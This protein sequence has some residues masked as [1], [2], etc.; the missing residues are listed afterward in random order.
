[1]SV[2]LS[3]STGRPSRSV[4][5]TKARKN[6]SFWARITF[7][8]SMFLACQ[9]T[10]RSST[11][12]GGGGVM[13]SGAVPLLAESR[14]STNSSSRPCAPPPRR[15]VSGRRSSG[16]LAWYLRH[17][18]LNQR[19]SRSMRVSP[20]RWSVA[21]GRT[22]SLALNTLTTSCPGP[23]SAGLNSSMR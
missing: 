19:S 10:S 6:R 18:S 17:S 8:F 9:M 7:L 23:G 20:I 21:P 13:F 4:P 22:L 1:M 12:S 2:D 5:W 3:S 16:G 15:M 11:C 14:I